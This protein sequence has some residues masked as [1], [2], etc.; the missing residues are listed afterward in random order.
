MTVA[1]ADTLLNQGD[2][3]DNLRRY[4]AWFPR[5][6]YGKNFTLWATFERRGLSNSWGNGS[7]MRV[8]PVAYVGNDLDTVL[9]MAAESAAVTH[10]YPEGIRGAQAT[11]IDCLETEKI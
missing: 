3:V 1:I 9:Q 6:G 5:A 10:N 8:S 7:A 2:Y 11:A 4:Y